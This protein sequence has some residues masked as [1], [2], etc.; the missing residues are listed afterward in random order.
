MEDLSEVITSAEFH[1]SHCHLF[2]YSSSRGTIR[3]CDMRDSAICDKHTL[4]FEQQDTPTD[5]SFFSEII[6][7]I[8][9][10]SFSPCGRY[11]LSRD[12][13]TVKLWDLVMS[14]RGPVSTFPVHDFLSPKLC[15]LYENDCIFDK[16]EVCWSHDAS[17]FMTG[18]YNNLFRVTSVNQQQE[19]LK[20]QIVQNQL[21][22]SKIKEW[23]FYNYKLTSKN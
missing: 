1:P 3:L 11:L 15:T 18:S 10:I 20:D 13:L 21:L 19:K 2:A 14:G 12:Y 7:S 6:A 5:R 4:L 16:F 9:D 23:E 8:S 17:Q 22:T